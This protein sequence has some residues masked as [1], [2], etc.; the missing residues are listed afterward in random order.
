MDSRGEARRT[1]DPTTGEQTPG[2]DG[3]GLRSLPTVNGPRPG[4]RSMEVLL[5]HLPPLEREFLRAG[6]ARVL[7]WTSNCGDAMRIIADAFPDATVVGVEIGSDGTREN[8][9]VTGEKFDVVLASDGLQV[10]EHPLEMLERQL[11]CCR[12]MYAALVPY[13]QLPLLPPARAQFREEA[14][15]EELAGFRRVAA[16]IVAADGPASD[17]RL[18]VVYA[19]PAYVERRV[20][21]DRIERLTERVAALEAAVERERMLSQ[22]FVVRAQHRVQQATDRVSRA[23]AEVAE[24]REALAAARA[25]ALHRD[26]ERATVQ[27]ELDAVLQSASW[28]LGHGIIRTLRR[29]V[30][31]RTS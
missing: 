7:A 11:R 29:L 24:V 25:E 30:P 16:A 8:A 5:A 26:V 31:R 6:P 2:A 15:P 12:T 19:T 23:D 4:R 21:T 14:F 13:N 27:A 1:E 28:R 3:G 22:Q 10:H 20:A 18:L 17:R 9:R